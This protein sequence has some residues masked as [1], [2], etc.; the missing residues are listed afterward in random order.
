MSRKFQRNSEQTDTFQRRTWKLKNPFFSMLS[1]PE[2][3]HDVWRG[4]SCLISVRQQK[5][6]G[7]IR[8]GHRE[9][10]QIN[11]YRSHVHQ[12]PLREQWDLR[13]FKFLIRGSLLLK[14][15]HLHCGNSWWRLRE[16]RRVSSKRWLLWF[17]SLSSFKPCQS[18]EEGEDVLAGWVRAG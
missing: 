16:W 14:A 9:A 5:E 11:E 17:V 15:K 2:Y 6:P 10:G 1:C 13:W 12:Q 18:T 4:S 3:E 7:K 8:E